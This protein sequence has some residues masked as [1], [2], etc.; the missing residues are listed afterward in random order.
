MTFFETYFRLSSPPHTKETHSLFSTY[1]PF[2]RYTAESQWAGLFW[3]S[4]WFCTCLFW[5]FLPYLRLPEDLPPGAYQLRIGSSYELPWAEPV[6]AAYVEITVEWGKSQ[7]VCNKKTQDIRDLARRVSRISV[8]PL[9]KRASLCSS[10]TNSRLCVLFVVSLCTL[11]VSRRCVLFVQTRRMCVARLCVLFVQTER[12]CRVSF[13]SHMG[14]VSDRLL[15]THWALLLE[16]FWRWYSLYSL[17]AVQ[18][19]ATRCHKTLVTQHVAS[20]L[21]A[22]PHQRVHQPF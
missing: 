6:E 11:C 17:Y 7:H 21:V 2:L 13:Y 5:Q 18:R 19:N 14:S 9:Y 10:C 16:F 22:S 8:Y 4:L 1:V 12:V 20:L 15:Q 3:V